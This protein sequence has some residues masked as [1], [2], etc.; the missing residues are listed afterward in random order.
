MVEDAH[1]AHK[2]HC[3]SRRQ[4]QT[5]CGLIQFGT[6][7]QKE[8]C[9]TEELS[10]LP[11]FKSTEHFFS[12]LHYITRTHLEMTSEHLIFHIVPV[13]PVTPHP[14]NLKLYRHFFLYHHQPKDLS[15]QRTEQ[16]MSECKPTGPH[17]GNN[18]L[19]FTASKANTSKCLI[20]ILLT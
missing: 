16:P 9:F 4:Q 17:C 15:H 19:H 11:A 18:P 5:Q 1:L 12:Y 2:G 3:G 14:S 13:V 6:L 10:E 8:E 20:I 7:R